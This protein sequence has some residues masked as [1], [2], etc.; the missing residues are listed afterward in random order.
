AVGARI[1]LPR[2]GEPFEP[3]SE[4]VPS[5]PWWRGVAVVPE[6]G[7]P[8]AGE[9]VGDTPRDTKEDTGDPETVPAG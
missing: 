4:T 7:W 9:T 1:A 5:E 8:S 3:T 2:P 6:G